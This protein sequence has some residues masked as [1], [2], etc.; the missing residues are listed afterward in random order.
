MPD[1][2]YSSASE[3][4]SAEQVRD[5][6]RQL[7]G[8]F[9]GR[10][11][12][13]AKARDMYRGEHWGHGGLTKPDTA[14][15]RY[16][17]VANYIRSTVD[18]S[19]QLLLGQ[20]PAIQVLPPG[21]D[22]E[23]RKKAEAMEALLY[24]CWDYNDA[25][26]VF[27][28]VAHN[29]VLC[30]RGLVYYWW[31]TKDKRPRFKSIAPDNFY[32]LYDGEDI[33]E[34]IFVS[35]RNTRVLQRA[36]PDLAK[37]IFPDEDGDDVFDES[38]WTER[39]G[40]VNDVLD[41]T[42]TTETAGR[43]PTAL[44]SMTTV[45][46][47]F[48]KSGN[49]VRLMGNA[50]FKQKIDYG[51]GTVPVIEFPF[52]LPG[53]ER[54]PR[55][56][57]DDLIDMNLYLDDL[58]SDSGNTIR[59]YA[60]PTVLDKKS[61]VSPQTIANALQKEGGIIPIRGDGD[62]VFLNWD[63]TPADFGEQYNRIKE[64]MH[65]LSGKPPASYGALE[66]N[67]SGVATNMALSPTTSSSEERSSIFGHRLQQLNAAILAMFEK[68]SK[69][70]VIDVRGVRPKR[71]GVKATTYYQASITGADIDGWY[72]NRIRWPS[73]LR[74]DDPVFVQ[75]ELAKL[76]SK[77]KAQSVYTTLEN[78]GIEDAEMEL[79]RIKEELEDPRLHP[80]QME[81]AVNAATALQ[82]AQLPTGMEG[83]DPMTA[84][85]NPEGSLDS[86]LI[87]QNAR[88]S[89]SPF[90]DTLSQNGY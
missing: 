55:S 44:S 57:I 25:P 56:E 9:S 84:G 72:V 65:D 68:Y 71:A 82:G 28:R 53:D 54:E 22:D 6:Y 10:N 32:P 85:G 80:E 35:R 2:N 19:V 63:G 88:A 13:Y 86:E 18:K 60:H 78:L 48:D 34:C 31:S 46:D 79:D 75:N 15:K 64:I 70:E 3:P 17:L 69:G 20:M 40:G 38:R 45:L 50:Y 1:S 30:R 7:Q 81:A 61:G 14:S 66:T 33:I 43:E 90:A 42:N 73:A 77:P 12:E 5:L 27:R 89:G 49:H 58:L 16:T 29:M 67:Q 23:S 62:I 4:L 37:D 52:N 8:T 51:L 41:Q 21:V 24:S 76:Q 36:Y 83:L 11:S 74:T 47:W 59:K 87:D 26:V 39:V